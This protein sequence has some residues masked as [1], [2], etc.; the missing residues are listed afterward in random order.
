MHYNNNCVISLIRNNFEVA[1]RV[2]RFFQ[3]RF[4][5]RHFIDKIGSF[6]TEILSLLRQPFG[7]TL[8]ARGRF[9]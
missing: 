8:L 2:K 6:G 5:S 7:P 3:N 9:N 1:N 4:F